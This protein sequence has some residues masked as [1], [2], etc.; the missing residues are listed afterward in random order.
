MMHYAWTTDVCDSF[1]GVSHIAWWEISEQSRFGFGKRTFLTVVFSLL[2]KSIFDSLFQSLDIWVLYPFILKSSL[3]NHLSDEMCLRSSIRPFSVLEMSM[4][5]AEILHILPGVRDVFRT[6]RIYRE[7]CKLWSLD[8]SRT[9]ISFWNIKWIRDRALYHGKEQIRSSSANTT[10]YEQCSEHTL[11][12]GMI[13][14]GWDRH[15]GLPS[16]TQAMQ[17]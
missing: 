17:C 15:V 2:S 13:L 10:S 9:T 7:A 8:F 1:D 6:P 5:N 4:Y 14:V 12:T 3:G 11:A 16:Q